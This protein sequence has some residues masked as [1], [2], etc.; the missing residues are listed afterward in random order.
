MLKFHTRDNCVRASDRPSGAAPARTSAGM[1]AARPWRAAS[2][3][4]VAPV[5]QLT[6]GVPRGGGSAN[7]GGGPNTMLWRDWGKTCVNIRSGGAGQ[8][9]WGHPSCRLHFCVAFAPVTLCS[10][11]SRP[12]AAPPPPAPRRRPRR[13]GAARRRRGGARTQQQRKIISP[14][15]KP[16]PAPSLWNNGFLHRTG[17]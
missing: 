17:W 11:G 13:R 14:R 10:S 4:G 15:R 8:R 9:R 16:P 5:K 3:S 1:T 7:S 12:P 2:T 6:N